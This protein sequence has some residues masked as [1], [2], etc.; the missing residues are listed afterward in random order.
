M[1]M[2]RSPVADPFKGKD[3]TALAGKLKHVALNTPLRFSME[4]LRPQSKNNS[5]FGNLSHHSFFSRHN[6]HPHRVTHIQGLNGVPICM[7][8]DGWSVLTPLSPHPMIKGQL[9]TT[10]LGVPGAH[11][12]IGDPHSNLVPR[13]TTEEPRRATQYSAETGRLIPPSSRATIR[14]TSY[15]LCQNNAKN[16]GK[17]VALSLQNQ[18]LLPLV[19]PPAY[20]PCLTIFLL[21]LYYTCARCFIEKPERKKR[22]QRPCIQ[23]LPV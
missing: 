14:H 6:P 10:I 17:D 4:A 21:G 5:R 11:M 1:E 3:I 19:L 12:P 9:S 15:Q 18:E 13:L 16:K 20:F 7:V 8:N 23:E 2:L 22:K